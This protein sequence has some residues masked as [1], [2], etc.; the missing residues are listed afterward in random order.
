MDANAILKEL[1]ELTS[2][3]ACSTMIHEHERAGELF[4]AL[5]QRLSKGGPLPADW[6]PKPKTAPAPKSYKDERICGHCQAERVHL[7]R[8]GGH[9]RDSSGDYQE[10]TDCGWWKTGAGDEYYPPFPVD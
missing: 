10:C 9:E 6:T 8:D 5:D 7:C 3:D 4:K 1:R 2:K